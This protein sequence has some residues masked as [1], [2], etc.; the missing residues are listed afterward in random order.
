VLKG[1]EQ[2]ITTITIDDMKDKPNRIDEKVRS[3]EKRLEKGLR[4]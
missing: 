1:Q 4:K 3:V 2:V